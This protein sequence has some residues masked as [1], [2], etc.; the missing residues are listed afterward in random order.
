MQRVARGCSAA[1]LIESKC[2]ALAPAVDLGRG[3]Q[4]VGAGVAVEQELALAVGAQRDEGERHHHDAGRLGTLDCRCNRLRI[5][6]G[7][8]DQI[9][10]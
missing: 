5:S 10:A 9:D 6:S 4:H 2:S 1:R 3:E 7:D 8:Q